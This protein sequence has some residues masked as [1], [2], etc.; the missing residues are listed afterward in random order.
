MAGDRAQALL[1]ILA[2]ATA[3][4]IDTEAPSMTCASNFLCRWGRATSCSVAHSRH[5]AKV[6]W[7]TY[8]F[9]LGECSKKMA[10]VPL[11]D[12]ILNRYVRIAELLYHHITNEAAVKEIGKKLY[13]FG[14][15]E[16]QRAVYYTFVH[17]FPTV[18]AGEADV[19][20]VI[21]IHCKGEIER[22]WDGIGNWKY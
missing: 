5:L 16:M 8:F 22:L 3:D 4:G 19:F 10:P 13:S 15:I 2:H 7:V 1:M 21:R 18:R 20:S 9:A 12:E 14:G 17:L 6:N 11:E